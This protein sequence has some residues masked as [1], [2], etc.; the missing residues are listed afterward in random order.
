MFGEKKRKINSVKNIVDW[1]SGVYLELCKERKQTE[2][3]VAATQHTRVHV[4]THAHGA[5]KH[6]H[7]NSHIDPHTCPHTHPLHDRGILSLNKP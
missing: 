5:C 4:R 7:I 6:K 3:K 1:T 2:A